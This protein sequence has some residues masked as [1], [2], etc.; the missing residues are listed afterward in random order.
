MHKAR[1]VLQAPS[2]AEES[3]R[4]QDRRQKARAAIACAQDARSTVRLSNDVI[5]QEDPERLADVQDSIREAIYT[6]LNICVSR[7]EALCPKEPSRLEQKAAAF[8]ASGR[9]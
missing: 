6:A 4:D 9:T 1:C 8:P 5:T 2:F 7:P 3:A